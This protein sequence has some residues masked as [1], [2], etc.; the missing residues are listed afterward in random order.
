M[1]HKNKN[2]CTVQLKFSHKK[3][4]EN[5]V[6]THKAIQKYIHIYTPILLTYA[7]Y[8]IFKWMSHF[9]NYKYSSTEYNEC[10]FKYR[11]STSEIRWKIT[12]NFDPSIICVFLKAQEVNSWFMK[13]VL[14]SCANIVYIC[15][16]LKMFF[17]I[18]NGVY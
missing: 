11:F 18:C 1:S 13:L 15:N 8:T 5:T 9:L 2:M 10:L 16:C 17:V 3:T 7:I 14:V 4:Q 6:V 12:E